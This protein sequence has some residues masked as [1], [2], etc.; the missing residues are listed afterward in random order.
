MPLPA[1]R[2]PADKRRLDPK[3]REAAIVT[4][5]IAFFAEQ[6]FDGST[7]DLAAR[8]GI[9]QP[10][11]YR[12]FPSK[13][14]LL[15]RVYEEVYLN[16]WKPEWGPALKDRSVPLEQ[17][18]TRFYQD[19]ARVLL[20]YEWVRLFMFAGLK[21]LDF[22]ARYLAFL[23]RTAFDLV[24]RE[25]RHERGLPTEPPISDAEVE[26]V[27]G[28]HA[29]IFYMGV[30]RFIYGMPFPDDLDA[31]L[32][33]RVRAFLKGAPEALASLD[34][35]VAAETKSK[36]RMA[37]KT[38]AETKAGIRTAVEGAAPRIR[39]KA[40]AAPVKAAPPTAK[41]GHR[42]RRDPPARSGN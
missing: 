25:L 20:T 26:L 33:L 4:A 38:A 7:R 24:V 37:T 2:T 40:I 28:L 14:A 32:A 3:A 12:Y 5:A 41:K 27:W 39:Q 35:P 29:S 17:R 10:L 19:Y 31:D 21:G 16:P 36:T 15:D 8:I 9:T 34:A 18:L 1:E 13:E 30:R 6:G 23:H 11:L 42:A 22:N